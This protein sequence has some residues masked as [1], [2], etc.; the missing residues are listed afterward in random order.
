MYMNDSF[1]KIYMK[2]DA[3]GPAAPPH[4]ENGGEAVHLRD[5]PAHC[6][7]VHPEIPE[8]PTRLRPPPLHVIAEAPPVQRPPTLSM[9]GRGLHHRRTLDRSSGGEGRG[10]RQLHVS[11]DGRRRASPLAANP[12]H[13]VS[14]EDLELVQGLPR[15]RGED[16]YTFCLNSMADHCT[17]SRC[18]QADGKGGIGRGR[19]RPNS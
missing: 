15:C 19:G 8:V 4:D 7:A 17:S 14:P 1:N 18:L 2:Y 6:F 10:L 12:A 16:G 11:E 5:L 9:I 13:P 3:R